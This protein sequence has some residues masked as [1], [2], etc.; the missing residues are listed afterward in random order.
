MKVAIHQP[1][2]FPWLGYF[3][4]IHACDT[5]VFLDH[6]V[7]NRSESNYTRRVECLNNQ[8]EKFYITIPILKKE[9][10][11]IPLNQWE[12]NC[13]SNGFPKKILDTLYFSY[14]KHPYFEDVYPLLEKYF[15]FSNSNSIVEKNIE[16]ISA[17]CIKL[18]LN[19]KFIRSSNLNISNHKTEMLINIISFL[20]GKTYISG[21]GGVTYQDPELFK[22]NNINLKTIAYN[23]FEYEQINSKKFIHGLSIVDC[24]MNLGYKKTFKLIS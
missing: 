14:K 20:D 13:N 3:Q 9:T 10:N 22:L 12:I 17:V 5:F 19:T 2:I 8:S 4:K 16:F 15:D 6:T 1:N 11:F 23:D 24:L 7:N 21:K 18:N